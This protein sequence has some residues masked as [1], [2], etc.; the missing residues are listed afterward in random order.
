MS[1]RLPHETLSETVR[2]LLPHIDPTGKGQVVID[3]LQS[4]LSI[5]SET[6]YYSVNGKGQ[7]IRA[8]INPTMTGAQERALDG[9]ARSWELT[10]QACQALALADAQVWATLHL[11]EITQRIAN[12]LD[13]LEP[14][15]RLPL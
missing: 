2:R 13:M 5:A 3:Q 9:I 11:A 14:L 7:E 6:H 8:L 15:K 10:D 4:A 12:Q 1:V